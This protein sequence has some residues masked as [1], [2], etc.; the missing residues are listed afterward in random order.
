MVIVTGDHASRHDSVRV[1]G[2]TAT[3]ADEILRIIEA[4]ATSC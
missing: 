2:I 3:Q 1:Y 4:M